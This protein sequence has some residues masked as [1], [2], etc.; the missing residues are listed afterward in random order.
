M[1]GDLSRVDSVRAQ[2]TVAGGTVSLDAALMPPPRAMATFTNLAIRNVELAPVLVDHLCQPYG[3]T[4]RLDLDGEA[5]LRLT[6]GSQSGGGSGRFRIGP[7][8]MV[9]TEVVDLVREIS[10]LAVVPAVL[11]TDPAPSRS[12][13]EF[14][15]ITGSYTIVNGVART[16]DLVYRARDV[17]VRAAG[18]YALADRRVAVE[19]TLS[20]GGNRVAGFVSGAPGSLRVVP[21]GVRL[22]DARDVRKFLGRLFR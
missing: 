2:A 20:E 7:G 6:N 8:K 9:G 4:G 22:Q 11:R 14:D 13:L 3:V 12:P 5:N 17:T 15:S 18:T 1:R 16:E 10:G 19:V 21:L